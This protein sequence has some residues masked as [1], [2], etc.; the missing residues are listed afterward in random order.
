MRRQERREL[1]LISTYKK[2][3]VRGDIRNIEDLKQKLIEADLDKRFYEASIM[4]TMFC[5]FDV[6]LYAPDESAVG[7]QL[8]AQ[9]G[10]PETSRQITQVFTHLRR[11]GA[12]SV[13][14]VA[15]LSGFGE[16]DNMFIIKA[17]KDPQKDEMIHEYF[18]GVTCTNA[19][20][21]W[22][23]NYAYILGAFKCQ[24]PIVQPDKRVSQW[25]GRGDRSTYVNY[26]VYEKI[27]G[28]ELKQEAATCSFDEYFT[29][30]IQLGFALQM[31]SEKCGFTHYDLHSE[32]VLMRTW[33]HRDFIIPYETPAGILYVRTN[34]I[35]TMIDFGR[36]HVQVGGEGFGVYGFE[37]HGVFP[38]ETRP[39]YD[40]YKVLMFSLYDMLQ[41][42]NRR[43]LERALPLLQLIDDRE[44][45]KTP[46]ELLSQINEERRTFFT[47][48][49]EVLPIER[50]GGEQKTLWTYLAEVERKF[51]NEWKRTISATPIPGV[52]I[53]ACEGFKPELAGA[54]ETCQRI[55]ADRYK[56]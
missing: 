4:A 40:I 11:I 35:A 3:N 25:C 46:E 36:S 53:L 42:G 1:E 22:T 19:M 5:L 8:L 47:F 52:P 39:W 41:S 9:G 7:G 28:V 37:G 38:S 24:P 12:E 21:R 43:C 23:P 29:W 54:V 49:R 31:G 51:P 17:P 34:K 16:L 32:N 14:G 26:I 45:K 27:P 55:T 2:C 20:R 48:S 56:K 50:P 13:D 6:V 18:I 10:F 33:S 44:F 30:F 15:L